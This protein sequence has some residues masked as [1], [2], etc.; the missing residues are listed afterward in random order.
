MIFPFCPRCGQPYSHDNPKMLK[1]DNCGYEFYLSPKP[2]NGL[3]IKNDQGEV[4]LVKRAHAPEKGK[5]DVAGGFVDRDETLEESAV[6][7]A[8]EEL[9]VEISDLKYL[10]SY[11]TYYLYQG[12]NFPNIVAMF[13]AKIASGQLRAADDALEIKF[14]AQDELPIDDLAF[15]F[16]KQALKDFLKN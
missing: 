10:G 6:R 16:I 5:W 14:F 4:L 11:V 12:V 9:G 15:P 2:C 7:E 1:C 3:F 8:K 13:E